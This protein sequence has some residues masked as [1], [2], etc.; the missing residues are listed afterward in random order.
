[1]SDK[2]I[3]DHQ[4]GDEGS[5]PTAGDVKVTEQGVNRSRRRFTGAGLSA[6]A[7]LTLASRPAFG[8]FSC[9]I[10]GHMSGNHS[11]PG[12]FDCFGREVSYYLPDD[13]NWPPGFAVTDLFNDVFS[14]SGRMEA[15]TLTLMEALELGTGSIPANAVAALFNTFTIGQESFG[16]SETTLMQFI[17]DSLDDAQLLTDLQFLNSARL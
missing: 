11:T 17:A 2:R 3:I 4:H 6:S 8:G 9:T 5:T 14:A 10:S 13:T 16:Y 7:I 12:G 15:S 1:M